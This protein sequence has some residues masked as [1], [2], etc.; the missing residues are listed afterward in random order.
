MGSFLLFFFFLRNSTD[1]GVPTHSLTLMSR[2]KN[3]EKKK[4]KTPLRGK[5]SMQGFLFRGVKPAAS[6]EG[7]TCNLEQ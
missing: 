7:G 1:I 5:E 4:G 3:K 6:Y 2:G